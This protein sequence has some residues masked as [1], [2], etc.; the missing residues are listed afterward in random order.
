M[1][2]N[3]NEDL[4]RTIIGNAIVRGYL[5]PFERQLG[6]EPF[7]FTPHKQMWGAL[8]ELDEDGSEIDTVSVHRTASKGGGFLYALSDVSKMVVGL[9]GDTKPADVQ[10]LKDLHTKR[11]M[12]RFAERLDERAKNGSA[13]AEIIDDA[14]KFLGSLRDEQAKANGVA[15]RAS[16]VFE[17][18]VKPRLEA[19]ARGEQIKVPTGFAR[20]D[21]SLRGGL[22][23]G[24]LTVLGAKP[25]QGKSAMMIQTAKQ[26]AKQGLGTYVCSREMLNFENGF[27][28]IAQDSDLLTQNHFGVNAPEY[29]LDKADEVIGQ[30]RTVPLY[31]D[32]RS[33]TVPEVAKEIRLLK[34]QGI[35]LKA[36]F[37]DYAQLMQIDDAWG[38]S[39]ANVLETIVYGLKDL[40]MSEQI[41][42]VVLAQFNREGISS[43][44][45]EMWHF[46]GSSAIEKAGNLVMLWTLD[47]A[48][49]I[50]RGVLR[51]AAA[52]SVALDSWGIEFD[53]AKALFRV[54]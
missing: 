11:K 46:E 3:T 17:M 8:L 27:R 54:L 43:E 39:R 37:V 45:P 21:A 42:V 7:A 47:D 38:K 53:G 2:L 26:I 48:S 41:A 40:A 20:M 10:H 34:D 24:E 13:P 1:G 6:I 50:R 4:E 52:R 49:P 44:Q 29:V 18:D 14:L 15:V 32:E 33:R 16:D 23:I 9:P 12:V 28:I 5:M 30:Y 35:E 19:M 22:G 25:K 51:I 31:L 36:A